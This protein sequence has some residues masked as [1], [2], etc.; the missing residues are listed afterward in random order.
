MWNPEAPQGYIGKNT[1]SHFF[2]A[3]ENEKLMEGFTKRGFI[4]ERNMD[5]DTF[6][7]LG[8][9]KIIHDKK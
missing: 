8:I 6:G 7:L 3:K 1:Y 5:L 9:K 4:V 2:Y